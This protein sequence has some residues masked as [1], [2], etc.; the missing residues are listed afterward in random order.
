MDLALE[1]SMLTLQDGKDRE[2]WLKW[3]GLYENGSRV[4]RFEQVRSL[5]DH[6]FL[7]ANHT[8][9]FTLNYFQ[10]DLSG[11]LVGKG[12]SLAPREEQGLA[13]HQAASGRLMLTIFGEN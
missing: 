6:L 2:V 7:V 3:T 8:Q 13:L 10:I 1:K 12:Y 11:M 4:I 5:E 9:D